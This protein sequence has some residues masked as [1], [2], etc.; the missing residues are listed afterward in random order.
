MN[1]A[2]SGR[3][4]KRG[5]GRGCSDPPRPSQSCTVPPPTAHTLVAPGISLSI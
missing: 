1:V 5:Q 2:I 3:G 4:I